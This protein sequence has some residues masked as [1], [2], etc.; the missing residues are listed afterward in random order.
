MPKVVFAISADGVDVTSN[1]LPQLI[2]ATVTESDQLNSDTLELVIDD[3]DGAIDAPRKGAVLGFLG[4]YEGNVRDYGQYEVDSVSFTGWPQRITVSAKSLSALK[5]AKQRQ[6]K[7]YSKEDYPT[8]GDIFTAVAKLAGLNAVIASG[9]GSIVNE[10]EAQS[11][12][13]GASFLTRIAE[14]LGAAVSVKNDRMVVVKN[15]AGVSAGGSIM[16]Q[17][18]VAPGLNLLSYQVREENEPKHGSVEATTYDRSR[19]RH[20]KVTVTTGET[21]P[22][23]KVRAP[24]KSLG[25]A[26]QAALARASDLRRMKGDASFN[27]DGDPFA[28]AG[29]FARVRGVRSNVDGVWKIKTVSHNYSADGPFTNGLQC[30]VPGQ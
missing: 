26:Q 7:S 22:P 4:G 13:D 3:V 20:N 18:D 6:T 10:F 12:E 2:S 23:F 14:R 15:G 16:D 1:I 28:Q 11:E 19:N 24:M 25:M 5:L 8:Y 9:I 29:A 21:G 30:E 27:I 17:I